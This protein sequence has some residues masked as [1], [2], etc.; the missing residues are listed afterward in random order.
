VVFG[1]L[2]LG[3]LVVGSLVLG[4]LVLGPVELGALVLGPL[5]GRLARR[6]RQ[7]RAVSHLTTTVGSPRSG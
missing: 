6:D 4:P 5:V 2:V 3:S 7:H 1:P